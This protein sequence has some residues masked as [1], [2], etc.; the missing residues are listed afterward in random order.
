MSTVPP[1]SRA[2]LWLCALVL[3][4]AVALL[5]REVLF[6]GAVYHMDDAAD[7]YYPARVVILRAFGEHTLPTWDR[8]AWCGWPVVA[9]PYYGTFYP[10]NVVFAIAGAVRGLGWSAALHALAAGLAMLWLL[11]RRKL[12]EGPA[13]LGAASFALSSFM[14]CRIR[15]IVFAQE[16]VWLALILV[17]VEGWIATRRRRELVLI[18]VAG[19][20]ALLCGALPLGLFVAL[21]VGAY[22]LGRLTRAERRLHALAGLAL[23]GAVGAV[24][25]AAQLLPTLA[26]LRESQRALPSDLTFASSY[27][28]AD[29]NYLA[30][31]I[32]P[33]ALGGELRGAWFGKY[34]HWEMSGWYA[35]AL[36]LLFAPFALGR[37][38]DGKR[39]A[40][41]YGLGAMAL[42]AIALAFGDKLPVNAFF[43][44][45]VPLYASLR[46]PTRALVMLLA[47]APILGAEGMAWVLAREVAPRRALGGVAAALALALG[48]GF[49]FA[50]TR[51]PAGTAAPIVASRVA[52]GHFALVAGTGLALVAL[53]FAGLITRRAAGGAL[54]LVTVCELLVVGRHSLQPKPSDWAPGTDRFAAVDWLLAQHPEDR[55]APAADG[56][57]RLHNVGMTYG[58]DGAGGYGSGPAWRFVNFLHVVNHGTPYQSKTLKDDLSAGWIRRW[59]TPLVDLMNVRWAIA[60][61][62]PAPGWI[63]RFHADPSAPPHARHEATWDAQLNVY[64]NPHPLPRA[65]VVYAA[66]LKTTPDAEVRALPLLDPR[67]RAIVDRAP[68]PAP[69]G[70]TRPFTPARITRA[71]RHALTVE[72]DAAAAGVLVVSETAYPGWSATVDGAPA[73]LLHADY[74]FRGVALAA[75]HHTV[76]LRYVSRPT[77]HGLAASALG[78][79]ALLMLQFAPWPGS[80]SR[81][82]RWTSGPPTARSSSTTT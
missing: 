67:A 68:K 56:P 59:D 60:P 48:A 58:M 36:P 9:N 23:A 39:R 81:N 43:F 28:W 31:L 18:A 3:A 70:G 5:H 24:I 64:E 50:L 49:A 10:P 55:F 20:M 53:T 2:W 22:A 16:M 69:E 11:R 82:R 19:G 79:V 25:G 66:D 12:D 62:A 6:S 74:A 47:A 4:A 15:H 13:L 72:A 46:C 51:A 37:G 27:A 76:E 8:Q 63:E 14:V 57:F 33:D 30:T 40:E 54:A 45:H 38:A 75:G 65:F 44:R 42:L 78:L 32:A 41:L 1:R 35:G 77:R 80:S 17:G 26:H 21:I 7:D 71:D 61:R 73:E 34:N 52:F 29:I